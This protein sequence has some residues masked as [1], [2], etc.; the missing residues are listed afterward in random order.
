MTIEEE[1]FKKSKP[2]E[3]KLKKYGFKKENNVYKIE[4]NFMDG[5]FKTII[6]IKDKKIKGKIIDLD[7]NEEYT[8]IRVEN[9][10]GQFVNKVK[11]EYKKI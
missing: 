10:Q 8:N 2:N 6:T 1:I 5:N 9:T 3:N 11:T 7:F 4:K